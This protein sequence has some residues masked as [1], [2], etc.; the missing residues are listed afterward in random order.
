MIRHDPYAVPPPAEPYDYIVDDEPIRR[1]PPG[2]P[3]LLQADRSALRLAPDCIY[4]SWRNEY[5]TVR[6]ET[7]AFDG[8]EPVTVL[9]VQGSV[10]LHPHGLGVDV[11]DFE[12]A[13]V[14]PAKEGLIS[15][16]AGG[17]DRGSVERKLLKVLDWYR[18]ELKLRESGEKPLLTATQLWLGEDWGRRP[19]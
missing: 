12:A 11:L 18:S 10:Y 5:V 15:V 16:A 6:E 2:N 3:R 4:R 1:M 8:Q 9:R 14:E 19:S 7:A 17:N 13:I